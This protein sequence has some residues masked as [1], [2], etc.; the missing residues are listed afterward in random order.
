MVDN[1]A[2]GRSW[3]DL[4]SYPDQDGNTHLFAIPWKADLKSLVWYVPEN[5]EDAATKCPRRW[6]ISRR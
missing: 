1:Y 2:A 5:F 4:S 6:K 3:A